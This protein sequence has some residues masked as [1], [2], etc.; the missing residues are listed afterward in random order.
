M[1]DIDLSD[2]AVVYELPLVKPLIEVVRLLDHYWSIDRYAHNLT[3]IDAERDLYD[4]L[5]KVWPSV[6]D[7]IEGQ[8]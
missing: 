5:V 1:S 2:P 8:S 3:Y 4:A 6:R 7:Y